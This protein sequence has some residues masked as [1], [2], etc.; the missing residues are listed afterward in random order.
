MTIERRL[1]TLETK[2]IGAPSRTHIICTRNGDVWIGDQATDESDA[3]FLDR[4][5]EWALGP[6]HRR[7]AGYVP[8]FTS[9]PWLTKPILSNQMPEP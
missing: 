6:A 2:V 4:V 3:A 5:T 1:A 7:V 8:E 9:A